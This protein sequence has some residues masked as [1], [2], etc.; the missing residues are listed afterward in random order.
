MSTRFI[1]LLVALTLAV[2]FLAPMAAL[3]LAMQTVPTDPQTVPPA[4]ESWNAILAI[5]L[6]LVIAVLTG[7]AWSDQAK[8]AVMLA[9]S[10]M[11]VVGGMFLRGE[12]QA[13]TMDE[14]VAKILATVV[15]VIALYYGVWKPIGA[16]GA[17]HR[18]TG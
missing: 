9:V 10:T 8:A 4:I 12:L 13:A 16:T 15:A 17:I 5:V 11:A 6:P 7:Q 18:L 14:A 3:A 1:R 2:A